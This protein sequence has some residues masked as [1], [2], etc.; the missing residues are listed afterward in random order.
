MERAP[1]IVSTSD[2]D[3]SARLAISTQ[4]RCELGII[5]LIT[6]WI[7]TTE[8]SCRIMEEM[9][10]KTRMFDMSSETENIAARPALPDSTIL[11]YMMLRCFF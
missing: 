5:D 10:E 6:S 11:L 4:S 1:T 2:K 7:S 8:F 3:P 9:E